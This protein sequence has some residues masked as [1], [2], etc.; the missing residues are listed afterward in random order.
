MVKVLISLQMETNI[1]VSIDMESH[2]ALVYIP[3]LMAV[4]LRVNLNMV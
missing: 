2:K 1:L 3:G 4:I